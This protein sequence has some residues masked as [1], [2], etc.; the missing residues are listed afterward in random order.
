MCFRF[1]KLIAVYVTKTNQPNFR[2]I[3]TDYYI[4]PHVFPISLTHITSNP[5]NLI[6]CRLSGKKPRSH[7]LD[8]FF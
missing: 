5:Q 7:F 8:S 6:L 2:I 3:A 4:L 1:P